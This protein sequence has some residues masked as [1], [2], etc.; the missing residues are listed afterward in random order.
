MCIASGWRIYG[1]RRRLRRPDAPVLLRLVRRGWIAGAAEIALDGLDFAAL[2]L[3]ILDVPEGFSVLRAARISDERLVA[4]DE[5]AVKI[6]TR[7]EGML[8]I[9]T[10]R[11][12]SALADAVVD[13][14]GE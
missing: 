13:R 1:I 11:F 7:N 2:Q 6:M 8:S 12:E 14:A 5:N 4:N 9:P 3:E 10:A